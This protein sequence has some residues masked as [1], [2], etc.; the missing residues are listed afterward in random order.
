MARLAV[1]VLLLA[2]WLILSG[3]FDPFHVGAGIVCAAL[4]T[5]LSFDLLL[6]DAWARFSAWRFAAY[7]PWLLAEMAVASLRVAWLVM[8]P[9]GLRPRIVRFRTGLRSDLA[10]TT[11]GNSITL[12]PGTVTMDVVGD[13]FVVHALTDQAADDLRGGAMERRVARMFGEAAADGA[14]TGTRP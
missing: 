1:F 8:R 11:L 5:A 7:V 13:E 4:V 12:T 9:A 3:H 14:D 6:L 2:F 10:R